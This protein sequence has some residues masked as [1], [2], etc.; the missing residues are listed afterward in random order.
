MSLEKAIKHKKEKRKEYRGAKAFD[1]TCRNHGTDPA[2][3]D[4]RL[5]QAKKQKQKVAYQYANYTFHDICVI[6]GVYLPEGQQVCNE[7]KK[8]YK[9]D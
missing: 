6:C 8:R 3:K 5:Y 9:I 2:S 7:C 4:N 1:A